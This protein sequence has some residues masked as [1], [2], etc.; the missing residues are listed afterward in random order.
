MTQPTSGQANRKLTVKLLLAVV[1]M[2]GFGFALVPLYDVMCKQLGINGKTNEV[3]AI[4]PKGMQIDESRTIRVEFMA[5]ISH[6][7]P[8]TFAPK[9]TH[10]DVHP[11]Q[12]IQTAYL[13][14]N[15]SGSDLVGQAV[16]SVSPGQ[17]AT[18]FNKIE[19]FCF[20][21]QPLMAKAHAEMPLIFYIEP[22]IPDT[23]H[24]LTLSYTLYNI[25]DKAEPQPALANAGIAVSQG[26]TQ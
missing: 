1:L 3:A 11:G 23:I 18:Y 7:M 19:C 10:I 12:V 13:A 26:A 14:D 16:P 20:S 24:T 6:N 8:W 9:V 17:G 25:T 5:H 15:L 4:Q 21:Q 2:F 22:D